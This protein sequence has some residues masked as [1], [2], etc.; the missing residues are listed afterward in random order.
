VRG[1][2]TEKGATHPYYSMSEQCEKSVR[3]VEIVNKE[4]GALGKYVVAA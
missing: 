1:I 2:D 3:I 4:L